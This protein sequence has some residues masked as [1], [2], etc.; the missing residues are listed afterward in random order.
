MHDFDP[1][2]TS[3][4]Y[5]VHTRS[6]HEKAVADAFPCRGIECLLP[7]YEAMSQWKDRRVLLTHPLFPGYLFVH[8]TAAEKLKVLTVPGVVSVLCKRPVHDAIDGTLIELLRNGSAMRN[9]QPHNFLSVGHEVTVIR[10][11]FA[12]MQGKLLQE[13][14]TQRVVISLPSIMRA[15]SVEVD[16]GDVRNS[17]ALVANSLPQAIY[18]RVCQ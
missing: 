12:G 6:N 2:Q 9:A 14:K 15:F 10:G 8:I 17:A 3:C 1:I 7:T 5:A 13:R 4:W 18:S 16:R 11:P